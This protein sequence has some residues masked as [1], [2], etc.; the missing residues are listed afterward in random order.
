MSARARGILFLNPRAGSFTL[1]DESELRTRAYESGLRV[2]EI[3]PDVDLRKVVREALDAGLRSFVVGGGDGSIHHVAQA[4][5]GTEGQLGIVPIGTVNHLARDLQLPLDW[6]AAFEVALGG[7][8]R[9]IDVGRVNNRYFLNSVML[10][11]YPTL[12]EYRERFRSTHHKWRAY[13]RAMRLALRSFPHVTL[14]VERD[15]R[16]ETIRTQLFV[17]SV[18]SYDLTQSGLVS[19]RTSLDDGRLTIYSLS[20][21]DRWSFVRAA[22]K[23]FRGKITD[24]DG[25]RRVRTA[26]LRVDYVRS[27]LKISIDG[28]VSDLAPPLQIAAVPASLLVRAPSTE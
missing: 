22:A 27:R 12:T 2:V 4:L 7:T 25:F 1:S 11:I 21:M 16:V 10:G 14:V 18:N 24:V 23:Y 17:V 9:Q 8:L 3:R 19:L 15:G 13:M 20:F 5:V 6:R 26:A 28:E